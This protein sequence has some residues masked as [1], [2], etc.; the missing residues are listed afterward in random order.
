MIR[1]YLLIAIRNFQRQKFFALLNMF[2]LAIGLAAAILI[3]LYVTDELQY[4]IMHPHYRNTY[5]LGIT[6]T[7]PEGQSFENNSAPGFFVKQLKEERSEV[8]DGIRI[9]YIGYP[10]SLHHKAADK[11]ILTEKIKWAEPGFEKILHFKLLTGNRNKIF[12]NVNTMV[13]SETGAKK[14]FGKSDP[15]GEVISVKHNFATDGKEIDVVVTGVFEDYPSNSHFK[16]DFILNVNAL[17]AVVPNFD[18]YMQGTRFGD[19]IEFFES[20]I[21]LKQ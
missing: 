2:G 7:N 12:E 21:V 18:N 6:F 9:D 15:I 16:P 19:R 8:E 17:R 14:L 20:Y 11:I 3:F 4:D 13:V 5:R 1:N 10:T